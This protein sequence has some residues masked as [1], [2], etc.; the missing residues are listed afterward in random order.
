MKGNILIAVIC[1]LLILILAGGYFFYSAISV[2]EPSEKAEIIT[3]E[4]IDKHKTI[5]SNIESKNNLPTNSNNTGKSNP[6][7]NES[8]KKE[9]KKKVNVEEKVVDQTLRTSTNKVEKVQ[10]IEKKYSSTK[11]TSD[12]EI[13]I[14]DSAENKPLPNHEVTLRIKVNQEAY[15]T[16]NLKSDH[17]GILRFS[18]YQAGSM[19]LQLFAKNYGVYAS[20]LKVFTGFNEYK[21]MLH[22]GGTLEISATSIDNKIIEEL[23]FEATNNFNFLPKESFVFDAGRGLHVLTN[24][25]VGSQTLTFK[26]PGFL[27]TPDY[28]IRIEPNKINFLEVK[29]QPARL[30]Y[31]DLNMKTKPEMIYVFKDEKKYQLN[32]ESETSERPETFKGANDLYEY[33]LDETYYK[34]LTI[35]ANNFLS[36]KVELIPG[37]DTYKIS[38]VEGFTGKLQI[39]DEQGM[40]VMGAEVKY[41]IRTGGPVTKDQ[42]M[43]AFSGGDGV[44]LLTDMNK[45]MFLMVTVSHKDYLTTIEDWLYDESSNNKKTMILRKGN[46]IKGKVTFET[47]GVMGAKLV[48][49]QEGTHK[50]KFNM[51]SESDGSFYFSNFAA[52]NTGGYY[53]QAHHPNYGFAKSKVF[54]YENNNQFIELSLTGEKSLSIRLED[55]KGSPLPNK[56]ITISHTNGD[57]KLSFGVVT[58][59][60]GCYDFYN[61][62]P[63]G[64][65]CT[66]LDEQLFVKNN[67]LQVPS[68]GIKVV[69]AV[70]K[71]LKRLIVTTQGGAPF[72]GVIQIKNS[73]LKSIN[74]MKGIDGNH[75]VDLPG[76]LGNFLLEAE[77]Y[78]VIIMGDHASL[79]ANTNDLVYE[80]KSGSNLK[81]KLVDEQTLSPIKFISVNIF[82]NKTKLRSKPTNELGEVLFEQLIGK[83][84]VSISG[85]EYATFSQDFDISQS[86]EFLIKLIKSGGLKGHLTFRE[87]VIGGHVFLKPNNAHSFPI[88]ADGNF[89]IND[90]TPG[91]YSVSFKENLK[92]GKN[93]HTKIPNKIQIQS[94]QIF[95][96]N[97]DDYLIKN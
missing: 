68:G 51:E 48:L 24:M 60:N 35:K 90:L 97:L 10:N 64:Y 46:G 91:E 1:I 28:L 69:T 19:Q 54:K 58:D 26:A 43:Y 4:S 2:E 45:K 93:I 39:N 36:Q 92:D 34:S 18:T 38:L 12:I 71:N 76:D 22:R 83:V 82:S 80:L 40:G 21:A 87:N 86:N 74:I 30:I 41:F 20:T 33:V 15:I 23:T 75:Y 95:E 53:I 32:K 50:P 6:V 52:S 79:V 88:G 55:S 31:F 62:T 96:I 89:T 66:L 49:Y 78:P 37:K 61:L 14:F 84:N 42:Y 70:Q 13:T 65:Y 3:T 72:K 16:E 17:N 73:A 9:I 29:L 25:P 7:F 47:R 94:G 77:G 56:T 85:N 44:A 63:G 81:L 59:E 8:P 11:E 27:A 5:T 57:P 67:D